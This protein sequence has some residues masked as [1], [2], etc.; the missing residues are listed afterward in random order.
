M[1]SWIVFHI[2][3]KNSLFLLSVIAT[4]P[5]N[6]KPSWQPGLST[7]RN[8]ANEV[9]IVDSVMTACQKFHTFSLVSSGVR[10]MKGLVIFTLFERLRYFPRRL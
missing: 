7:T 9:V 6:S 3:S 5:A 2:N 8:L 4:V 1:G 10:T